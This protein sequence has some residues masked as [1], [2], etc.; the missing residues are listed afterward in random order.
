M[1]WTCFNKR[2]NATKFGVNS[3]D[4]FPLKC[5]FQTTDGRT[6]ND[7]CT[8]EVALLTHLGI[9]EDVN[10]QRV[11]YSLSNNTYMYQGYAA[12]F[13]P[14]TGNA[15]VIHFCELS[16]LCSVMLYIMQF[17][18]YLTYKSSSSPPQPKKIFENPLILWKVSRLKA[19]TPPKQ[20]PYINLKE[21]GLKVWLVLPLLVTPL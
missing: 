12:Y 2:I 13:A 14:A 6:P 4:D 15:C 10:K 3:L 1:V 21:N 16:C 11:L 18:S 9:A 5:V 17:S 7:A 20:F 19:S 8:K